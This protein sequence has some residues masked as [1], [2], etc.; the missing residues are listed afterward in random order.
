ML[1]INHTDRTEDDGDE[2][3]DV[4]EAGSNSSSPDQEE[5]VFQTPSH[6]LAT[7][8]HFLLDSQVDPEAEIQVRETAGTDS[9]GSLCWNMF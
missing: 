4:A 6:F 3:N 9:Q 8:V 2:T 1:K 5:S 7:F